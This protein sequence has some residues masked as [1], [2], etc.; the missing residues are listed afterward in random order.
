MRTQIH[1]PTPE[2][3]KRL[4][5]LGFVWDVLEY[6]WE[7]GFKYLVAYKE[8][9]GD[10]CVKLK[11]LYHDY[12]LGA[13]VIRQRSNQCK[14]TSER[15]KRLDEL[16]VVWDPLKSQWEQGFKNLVA[17]KKEFGDCSISQ[18]SQYLGYRLGQWVRVQRSNKNKLTRERF[19]RLDALGL[20]WNHFDQST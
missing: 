2:R 20:K 9:F 7:E 17:Y 12:K 5:E 6:Q 4:D 19:N 8:E 11:P 13:W 1:Q 16:G 18:S 3:I 10:C 14:L 15:F